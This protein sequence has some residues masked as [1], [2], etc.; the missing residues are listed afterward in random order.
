MSALG[1]NGQV[2]GGFLPYFLLVRPLCVR[3][4]DKGL[5]RL[6]HFSTCLASSWRS[7]TLYAPNFTPPGWVSFDWFHSHL[8]R[9]S[10]TG[11]H[12]LLSTSVWLAADTV[13]R[14]KCVCAVLMLAALCSKA[15]AQQ[16]AQADALNDI[17][18]RAQSL[19]P[20]EA[21]VISHNGSIVAERGYRG[22]TTT[23]PTNIK[24]ASK[25]IISALVGIAIDK[26][27][28]E[29][30]DQRV[31]PL[32]SQDLPANPDPLLQQLTIG[33]LV[34]MRAGLG[35]TSGANYGAWVTSRN[36]VRAALARPFEDRPGGRMIY[37][38]GSTHLLSAILTRQTG[39]STLQLA[40]DWLGP[41]DGFSIGS[42]ERDP[43]GIYMGGN[44]MAMSPRSLLAF[45]EL[46]RNG[47]IA[48]DGARLIS[49]DWIQSS[50]QRHTQSPWTGHGH[51][52]AWFLATIAGE[53][54]Y[55]G[56]GY[57]G[58][59]LYVVPSLGLTVVMTSDESASAARTG[60]RNDLHRLL[61]DIVRSIKA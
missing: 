33:D 45:G 41:V 31:A 59:M 25:L 20:L 29:G 48:P 7:F 56:W 52:Y 8:C 54:V 39:R 38:T 23:S 51:G 11:E 2:Q 28:L 13:R 3:L 53:D 6:L 43:Q 34:T 60:H 42:W 36:W 12:A 44:Q 18:D 30:I 50:W 14:I 55:Y 26:D 49:E 61:G 10:D 22:H 17:L 32:L 40:R 1:R 37:S 47:G 4:P 9:H 16:V 15:G 57:G 5:L 35:S 58:Q 27:V 24:S 21:V 46:Y 19:Q